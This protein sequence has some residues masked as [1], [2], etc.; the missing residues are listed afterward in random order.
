MHYLYILYGL[1]GL[2]FLVFIHELG[3]YLVARYFQ[4]R[5]DTFSI[6]FGP[7]LISWVRKDTEYKI[8]CIPFGG[9]VKVAGMDEESDEAG[10]Y[11]QA[12]PYQRLLMVVAGPLVNLV[13]AFLGFCMIFFTSGFLKDSVDSSRLIGMVD[14]TSELYEK[15]IRP[16]D[17]LTSI[18]G[19]E[20]KGRKELFFHAVL[21]IPKSRVK[22]E[23]INY[24]A[25]TKKPF[26]L[27]VEPK[28]EVISGY[29]I[30]SIGLSNPASYL[31]FDPKRVKGAAMVENSPMK[32][33]GLIDGDRLIWV[34]GE[35][36]FSKEQLQQVLADKSAY[37]TVLRDHKMIHVKVP[38]SPLSDFVLSNDQKEDI[39]DLKFDAKLSLNQDVLFIPYLTDQDG[40]VVASFSKIDSG[41]LRPNDRILAVD[42]IKTVFGSDV[43]KLLQTKHI[44]AIVA[45][46]SYAPLAQ[47]ES[48]S[49]FFQEVKFFDLHQL[50]SKIGVQQAN[51][52]V[53]NIRLLKPFQPMVIEHLGEKYYRLGVSL[54][55]RQVVV[56]PN[57]FQQ[58][59]ATIQEITRLFS[60]LSQGEL[61][62]K[63][64]SGPIGIVGA[65][66]KGWSES[67]KDGIFW[68][69]TISLNLG[70][71]N[72][73]PLPVLDGG[74]ILFNL[75]EM[76]TRKRIHRKVMEKILI[77]FVLLLIGFALF[78]TFHDLMKIFSF[79]GF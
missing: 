18:N 63:F 27:E 48:Q 50:I 56:N 3:H 59:K 26:D 36:I 53:G 46:D 68:L 38:K 69:S 11:F 73:L 22:G 9:Y 7:T 28:K 64:L 35:L 4:M 77:P 70:V 76:V 61:S 51:L 66:Q 8:G 57:P 32:D 29:E 6:G 37:L 74:H 23:S 78:T 31:I 19:Q 72:L 33:A 21:D 12:K 17:R 71:M 43:L 44:V 25:G 62:P 34:N 10:S 67:F 52:E 5:V 47:N 55:D 49:P 41:L 60:H 58:F 2:S 65:M 54:V 79:V 45:H 1:I 20:V 24:L 14:P 30:R 15:G 75:F 40:I 16:G 13:F 39:N 42:G